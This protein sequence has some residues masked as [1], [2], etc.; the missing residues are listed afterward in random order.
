MSDLV[1]EMLSVIEGNDREIGEVVLL[2]QLLPNLAKLYTDMKVIDPDHAR[3][4]MAHY[5]TWL[6]GPK[7]C[8]TGGQGEYRNL[9]QVRAPLPLAVFSPSFMTSA[10]MEPWRV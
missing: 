1:T 6:R 2:T 9:G 5:R 8:P 3:L 4:C 7:N 10:R